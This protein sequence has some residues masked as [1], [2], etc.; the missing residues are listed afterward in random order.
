MGLRCCL[1]QLAKHLLGP[2][3]IDRHLDNFLLIEKSAEDFWFL[4]NLL[5][6]LLFLF[7]SPLIPHFILSFYIQPLIVLY[8]LDSFGLLLWPFYLCDPPH[9]DRTFIRLSR[10]EV[11]KIL[12]AKFRFFLNPKSNYVHIHCLCLLSPVV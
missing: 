5:F 9:F 10:L 7:L 6:F 3:L 2:V 11:L 4:F 1:L 8:L 12:Y